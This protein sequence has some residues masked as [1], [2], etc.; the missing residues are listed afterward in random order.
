MGLA[1][2]LL[3]KKDLVEFTCDTSS[4]QIQKHNYLFQSWLNS[5]KEKI[6][7]IMFSCV[8]RITLD[9]AN[10]Q[11]RSKWLTNFLRVDSTKGA[12]KESSL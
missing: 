7:L 12:F 5:C 2:F 4:M 9:F 10:I 8:L 6:V 3:S 1:K 11:H